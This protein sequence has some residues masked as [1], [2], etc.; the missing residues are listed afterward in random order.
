[1]I[2]T[3]GRSIPFYAISGQ[4]SCSFYARSVHFA[5]LESRTMDR[6]GCKY[7][8]HQCLADVIFFVYFRKLQNQVAVFNEI[9]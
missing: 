3:E 5:Y 4:F 7:R 1:M 2:E 8:S 6:R 9:N